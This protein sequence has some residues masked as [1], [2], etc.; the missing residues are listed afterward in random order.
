MLLILPLKSTK[1]IDIETSLRIWTDTS[2]AQYSAED[3]SSDLKRLN[4]LRSDI[5]ECISSPTSHSYACAN[6]ALPDL[7]QYHAC[8]VEC[9][10]HGFPGEARDAD[11]NGLLDAGVH[12]DWSN[13]FQAYGDDTDDHTHLSPKSV[14]HLNYERMCVLWNIAALMTYQAA[15]EQTWSTIESRTNIIQLYQTAARILRYIQY[16]VRDL[17]IHE[18]DWTLDLSHDALEMC[19]QVCLVQGQLCAYVALKEKIHS[20]APSSTFTLLSKIAAGVAMHADEGLV[21]SQALSIK[22]TQ[23][24]KVLGGHLKLVSMLFH[25]RSEFLVAQVEKKNGRYGIEI[26]RLERTVNMTKEGMEFM[27]SKAFA[28]AG[29]EGPTMLGSLPSSIESLLSNAKS[30]LIHI[31]EENSRVYFEKVPDSNVMEKI[32]AKDVME[33]DIEDNR[34]LPVELMPV[35]LERPMFVYNSNK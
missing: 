34:V 35:S 29:K 10:N 8:L 31:S 1:K 25:A 2:H 19:Q 30:R 7:I 9:L 13:A 16:T 5:S 4:A 20:Q 27:R 12:F 3:I 32:A 21:A 18:G 22:N 24:S 15:S 14:C 17:N 11:V 33:Y 6:N 28:Q 26:A 23:G